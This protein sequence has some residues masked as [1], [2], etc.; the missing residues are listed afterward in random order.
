[1]TK[2]EVKKL[3]F[4]V[5]NSKTKELIE[6]FDKI[7]PR[8]F[9][10][11]NAIKLFWK[12][13]DINILEIWC[14]SWRE[15]SYIRNFSKNYVWIDIS[16]EAIEYA[17]WKFQ[18]WEFIVWDIEEYNFDK[19][20][21]IIFAFA[22]LIHS[23]KETTIKLFDKF[24]EILNNNWIVYISMKSSEKYSEIT[25]TDE[26][27][28]RIYYHYSLEDYRKFS[29]KKFEIIYE[30]KQNFNNQ[31]WFTICFKKTLKK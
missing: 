1:M 10:I 17:K 27:W 2:K 3:N 23:D 20:L 5:Y 30:D 19:K 14:F 29:W 7:W 15:Y 9:D 13:I 26:F 11:D 24:Y 6:K 28:T 8:I 31:D 25:K 12:S 16:K 22:S 4:E 21:D 18:D